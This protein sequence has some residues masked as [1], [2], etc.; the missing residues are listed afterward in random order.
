M[1]ALAKSRVGSSSGI[2]DDEWTYSCCFFWTKKS[3]NDF[4]ISF[5]VSDV[6]MISASQTW[7]NTRYDIHT[8][9]VLRLTFHYHKKW[10]QRCTP[11]QY[12]KFLTVLIANFHFSKVLTSKFLENN[13]FP[14]WKWEKCYNLFLFSIFT[15][16]C[17]VMAEIKVPVLNQVPCH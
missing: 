8:H 7:N 1:P 9:R 4:R 2:V 15:L 17:N 11:I 12:T 14:V 10:I 16:D 6:F 5:A 13:N 3:M